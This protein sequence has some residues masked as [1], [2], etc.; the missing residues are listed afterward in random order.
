MGERPSDSNLIKTLSKVR[1]MSMIF[2]KHI[3][4]KIF[5]SKKN[6]IRVKLLALLVLVIAIFGPG[7]CG[8]GV[9]YDEKNKQLIVKKNDLILSY[10]D[11][12]IGDEIKVDTILLK[13]GR[14]GLVRTTYF[15]VSMHSR[16]SIL[17]EDFRLDYTN[18][19]IS[20]CGTNEISILTNQ[21]NGC[22]SNGLKIALYNQKQLVVD[23]VQ[24]GRITYVGHRDNT[25]IIWIDAKRSDGQHVHVPVGVSGVAKTESV[26]LTIEAR[27]KCDYVIQ[28]NLYE[29]GVF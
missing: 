6:Y 23:E 16:L 7:C 18:G 9:S 4:S 1:F 26:L 3:C 5:F 27:E 19:R 15:E 13:K 24:E 11:K 28:E 12:R 21:Y 10:K 14:D 17:E 29:F 20:L 22:V 2:F 25:H 8:P